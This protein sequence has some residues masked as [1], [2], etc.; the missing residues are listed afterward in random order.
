MMDYRHL[1][2]IVAVVLFV[3]A[4]ELYVLIKH[5]QI[6]LKIVDALERH[7]ITEET[8]ETSES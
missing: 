8:E 7:G 5:N 4:V 6:L 1:I 2:L 3:D